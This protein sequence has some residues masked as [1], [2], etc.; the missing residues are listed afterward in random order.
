MRVAIIIAGLL[1]PH[2][3]G[4]ASFE[5]AKAKT[6]LE[7]AICGDAALSAADE[8]LARAYT[9]GLRKLGDSADILRRTQRLWLQALQKQPPGSTAGRDVASVL[10]DYRERTEELQAIP[11]YP[12]P[13]EP[14]EGET[15]DYKNTPPGYDLTLRFILACNE[16]TACPGPA[17]LVVRPAG[18]PEV[19]QVINIPAV[20]DCC[21]R[22]LVDA[23]DYNFDGTPDIAVTSD[24]PGGYGSYGSN[25]F[26]FDRARS[27]FVY[28]AAITA[29]TVT[30]TFELDPAK[31]RIE[32]G[33]KSGVGYHENTIYRL[34]GNNPVPES[35]HIEDGGFENGRGRIIDS[36]WVNGRWVD[37]V[38]RMPE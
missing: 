5:C 23:D 26:L 34:D 1:L 37:K 15:L 31:K 4:A 2:A 18:R 35:R 10:R 38:R 36:R 25:V 13:D 20:Y 19:R 29:L 33:M 6:P 27:R 21:G 3:A 32:T 7:R 30:L 11:D 24:E 9:D 22:S 8:D 17:Q 14:V 12:G 16:P 28:N